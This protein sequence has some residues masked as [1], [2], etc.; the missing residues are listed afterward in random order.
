[1]ASLMEN[2]IDVLSKESDEYEALLGLSM[3]KTPIIV[4]GNLQDLQ[5]IT[6]EEQEVVGR[7]HN[8]DRNR[9]SITKDIANVLNMDVEKMKLSDM[10]EVLAGRPAEQENLIR[11]QE[12]LSDIVHRVQRVNSQNSVL[13]SQALEM[14]GYEINLFRSMKKAPETA[15]YNRG[16]FSTGSSFDSGTTGFDAKQ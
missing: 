8:L 2:L 6:D 3:K 16:A 12:K 13:I 7:I 1:M 10:V 9:V 5:K 15:N 14:V 4:S 11:V